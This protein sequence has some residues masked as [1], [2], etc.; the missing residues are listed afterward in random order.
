VRLPDDVA[1]PVVPKTWNLAAEV[2]VPPIAKSSVI[3]RG[4]TTP[5]F[6]W[7]I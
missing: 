6:L 3:F 2:L 5:A 1:L 7:N 4:E